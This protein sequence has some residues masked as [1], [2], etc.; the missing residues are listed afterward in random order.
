MLP[1]VT[2]TTAFSIFTL[3]TRKSIRARSI[4]S[5]P[6]NSI[7]INTCNRALEQNGAQ[8]CSKQKNP[9]N[10]II[11]IYP[12]KETHPRMSASKKRNTNIVIQVATQ[13]EFYIQQQTN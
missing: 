2:H 1:V 7:R 8:T 5:G 13:Q 9:I 3:N 12:K 4:P 10:A 6:N 11:W